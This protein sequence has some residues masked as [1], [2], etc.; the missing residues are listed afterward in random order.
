[1]LAAYELAVQES[2]RADEEE[3]EAAERSRSGGRSEDGGS[4]PQLLATLAEVLAEVPGN[5]RT[6]SRPTLRRGLPITDYPQAKLVQL[7]RWIES[8]DRLRTEDELLEEMMRELGFRKRG[9]RIVIAIN[10]AIL[11]ARR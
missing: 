10:Q 1:M 2:D 9:S 6:G 8:D 7:V 3:V 4:D 5:H 11:Q